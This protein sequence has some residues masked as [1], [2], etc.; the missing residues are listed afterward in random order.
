MEQ[1]R[2]I[3]GVYVKDAKK[4]KGKAVIGIAIAAIILASVFAATVPM[5]SA[6]SRCDNFN[7]I[8]VQPTPQKVL[9]GQNLE[10]EGFTG[11]AVVCRLVG[12]DIVN[13]YPADGNN[14]IYNVNWPT[15]GA[16]YVNYDSVTKDYAAPLSV[17]DVNM[18]LELRVGRTKVSSIAVGTMLRVDTAGINLFDEDLVN[19][20]VI[21]PEGQI[22]YDAINNQCF[23]RLSVADLKNYGDGGLRTDGWKIGDYTFQVKARPEC[24]CGLEAESATRALKIKTGELAIEAETT[25]CI[26]LQTV[27]LTVTGVADD[28]IKV[29]A[30]SPT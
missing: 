13:T 3:K 2:R 7:H 21:G 29:E 10:F 15:S 14:R 17:E 20:V 5:V 25:S 27:R 9:I 4:V 6:E 11:I 30:L 22:K 26:E 23:T 12:G 19:L 8:V 28:E 16:Y 18:P 1:R 24:A